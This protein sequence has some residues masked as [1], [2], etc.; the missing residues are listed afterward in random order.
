M[1]VY[2]YDDSGNMVRDGTYTYRYDP[3]N[4][5]VKVQK[6]GPYGRLTLGDAV[7]SPL[8]YTTG[9]N[10]NW[11][12][13]NGGE[14][15]EDMSAP[16]SPSL[17]QGQE[18]W[19]Q[20]TVE[21]AGTFSFWAKIDPAG[22]SNELKFY[23][24]DTL[25]YGCES[26]EWEQFSW[27][28]TGAGTHTLK[29]VYRRNSQSTAGTGYVDDVGW[30]GSLPALPP[31]EPA[32]TNWRYLEYTYDASGRRIEK[33]YDYETVTKYVYDGDHCIAEYNAYNQ[34]KR[35]YIY[36]PGVDQ[37]ICLIDSMTS[38]AVTSYYHFD[39][40][41]S[42]TALTNSSGNT[43]EVYEYDVYGR[44]GATDAN[45]PN[46]I[47]F[48]GREYDKETGLYYYRARYYNPQI[49]RFLQTDP[50]GYEAG[51]NL[52]RYCRNNS[53]NS[54][55]PF[56]LDPTDKKKLSG[57]RDF[58]SPDAAALAAS[59]DIFENGDCIEYLYFIYAY[60]NP[61]DPCKVLYGY[62]APLPGEEHAMPLGSELEAAELVPAPYTGVVAFGHSHP[63]S[64][65]DEER[66]RFS[67]DDFNTIDDWG[68]DAYL[69]TG[70]GDVWAY[71]MPESSFRYVGH[72]G[73]G[74][75]YP[76]GPQDPLAPPAEQKGLSMSPQG[77]TN[78]RRR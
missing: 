53:V 14:G 23:V 69:L 58:N 4:R 35:K 74:P 27:A 41:G 40:L 48:T 68:I 54:T 1:H 46:R 11:T 45:H 47:L 59:Q 12:A 77:E 36:G 16:S 70:W 3:E 75:A 31:P 60:K 39:A 56:G 21:G 55:D 57:A 29:W 63:P 20:T 2:R 8:T 49:G 37:P 51:M 19:L 33:K 26:G 50:V 5:L 25:R 61:A 43:V 24:D 62:T 28:V 72:V 38:P 22:V 10:G 66:T 73:L 18:S 44:V 32:A 65:F 15:H 64:A 17:A 7:E 34:L 30:T 42:V 9:G 6:S 71:D 13:A 76:E 78:R 67:R 52:Y